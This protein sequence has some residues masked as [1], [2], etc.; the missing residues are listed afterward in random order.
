MGATERAGSRKYCLG[1]QGGTSWLHDLM[2]LTQR[3]VLGL[4]VLIC[5]AGMVVVPASESPEVD[6]GQHL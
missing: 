2:L 3:T 4:G 5:T 1:G 6:M